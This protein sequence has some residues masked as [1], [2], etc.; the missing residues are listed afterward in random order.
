VH[1]RTTLRSGV[2]LQFKLQ[3]TETCQSLGSDRG[4]LADTF[5]TG[6]S[7]RSKGA[8]GAV[9]KKRNEGP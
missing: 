1:G 9:I 5:L 4:L 8:R 6:N 7:F 2:L 3:V